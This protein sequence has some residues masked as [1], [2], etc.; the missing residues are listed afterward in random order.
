MTEE[1]LV[2]RIDSYHS[3]DIVELLE[4]LELEDRIREERLIV[5]K[6]NYCHARAPETGTVTHPEHLRGVLQYLSRFEGL[7]VVVGDGIA[8]TIKEDYRDTSPAFRIAG[9]YDVLRDF[10]QVELVDFRLDEWVEV[11]LPFGFNFRKVHIAKNALRG[12]ILNLAKLKGHHRVGVTGGMKN[13]MGTMKVRK[14]FHGDNTGAFLHENVYDLYSFFK[15]RI[16]C[17]LLDGIVSMR[18]RPFDGETTRFNILLAGKDTARVDYVASNEIRYPV[19]AYVTYA[20]N[21]GVPR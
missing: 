10:P 14:P 5:V 4:T 12:P 19:P 7:H 1:I 21:G 16:V 18:D 9:V 17:T 8:E 11:Q 13:L 6:P 2:R 3:R 20:L 15:D